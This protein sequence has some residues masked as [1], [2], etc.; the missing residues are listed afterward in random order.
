MIGNFSLKDVTV[1]CLSVFLDG[2]STTT[3]TTLFNLYSLANNP[4]AQ[5]IASLVQTDLLNGYS[6]RFDCRRKCTPKSSKW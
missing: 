2:L 1:L 4:R 6:F 3:P 5:V